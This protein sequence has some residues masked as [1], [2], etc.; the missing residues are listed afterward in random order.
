MRTTLL[1]LSIVVVGCAEREQQ[2][3][4][5]DEGGS[6]TGDTIEATDRSA[7]PDSV[8]QPCPSQITEHPPSREARLLAAYKICPGC[9]A[10][11]PEY[12]MKEHGR[13]ATYLYEDGR[14]L[15]REQAPIGFVHRFQEK[16]VTEA[17]ACG[18]LDGVDLDGLADEALLEGSIMY[19]EATDAPATLVYL[20]DGKD[21]LE[22]DLHGSVHDDF[23]LTPESAARAANSAQLALN[24]SAMTTGGALYTSDGLAMWATTGEA[25][26]LAC[27]SDPVLPE[28]PFEDVPLLDMQEM[29]F[30]ERTIPLI[31][32]GTAAQEVRDWAL[33]QEV[34][35]PC[36]KLA[37][38]HGEQD[39]QVIL[40]DMPPDGFEG[41]PV[42]PCWTTGC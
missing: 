37:V 18:L 33:E 11:L 39:W 23:G 41:H 6:P 21:H 29:E 14:L 17:E 38:N 5:G 22:T 12:L 4:T 1:L 19:R 10:N 26:E 2:S 16:T 9:M 36:S 15:F 40:V 8:Q 27:P 24:L 34:E 42:S 28:W 30:A 31:L 7:S 35:S 3:P 13:P 20:W 25:V 32:E